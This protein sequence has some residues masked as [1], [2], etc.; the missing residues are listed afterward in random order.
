MGGSSSFTGSC[1]RGGCGDG[2]EEKWDL[3]VRVW[4]ERGERKRGGRYKCSF[5][6]MIAIAVFSR[7]SLVLAGEAATATKC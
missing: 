3:K 7:S 2:E 5:D 6:L 1:W 4:V